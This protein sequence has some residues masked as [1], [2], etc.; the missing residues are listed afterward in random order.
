MNYTLKPLKKLLS[1]V[2]IASI[3]LI[4]FS[5]LAEAFN[6]YSS[7]DVQQGGTVEIRIPTEDITSLSGSLDGKEVKFYEVH[8]VPKLDEPISRAEFLAMMFE[9]HD[10]GEIDISEAQGFPDLP[11][12]NPYYE[13]IIKAEALGI[14]NGYEDGFFRPYTTITRGQTAKIIVEAFD[15]AEILDLAP[16]FSD[17]RKNH[18][19]RNYIEQAVK[20]ELFHGYPD[21]LMRPD[22][23]INFSEAEIVIRRAAVPQNFVDLGEKSYFRAFIGIHRTSQVT[24]KKL[25]LSLTR[26]EE[27]QDRTIDLNVKYRDFP[28]TSFS[29]DEEKNK[30]FG[31]EDQDK[32]WAM[33]DGARE[34]T[35][36]KQLWDGPF[37]LPTQGELTL[38]F[39]EKLYINGNY[40]GSHFGHD[41]ANIEGTEIFAP[42]S[43]IV[44]LA[45]YTP[46]FGNTIVI[47]HGQNL[48]TMYLHLSELKTEYG[49][50][51]EKGD[52]I[53]LMGTTGISTG[54]HL[55]FTTFIGHI[56]VDSEEWA[57]TSTN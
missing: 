3:I 54:P 32:T 51:V 30:L 45:D 1:R 23:D 11:S 21:G 53:G 24:T 38:G 47:D 55:H 46:S 6:P 2:I 16:E 52:L 13:V 14:I 48:F 40:A 36:D 7:R 5:S 34:Y 31:Q 44:T 8:A 49:K 39:G 29:L 4:S 37:I 26:G 18:I 33:V 57:E 35:S 56:I 10:F 25:T 12:D 42:N 22:R 19:F 28:V 20:A 27:T 17:V 50:S 15:P 9:N 41:Y 43:G